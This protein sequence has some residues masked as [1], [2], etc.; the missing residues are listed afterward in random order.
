M[1]HSD[2]NSVQLIAVT[3]NLSRE[4]HFMMGYVQLFD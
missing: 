4:F 2:Y 1:N 3:M